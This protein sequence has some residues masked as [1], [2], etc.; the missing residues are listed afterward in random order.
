[1]RVFLS[2][3]GER[4]RAVAEALRD[5]LPNV[6]QA[7]EPWV[8]AS[9][10]E[11]GARWSADVARELEQTQVGVICLTS[12]NLNA[13][14]ILFETGALSKTLDNTF[15]CPYLLDITPTEVKAPLA[16]FQLTVAQKEDTRKLVHTINRAQRE[17]ALP[18]NRI[19][20][21]FDRFWP[22]LEAQLA[23]IP[24]AT[25][26]KAPPRPEREILEEILGIV[27]TLARDSKEDIFKQIIMLLPGT[28]EG[29]ETGEK[30]WIDMEKNIR[31]YLVNHSI[32]TKPF[33]KFQPRKTSAEKEDESNNKE[34]SGEE[35]K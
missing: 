31:N 14:W 16:Q 33:L 15:V 18:E 13:P 6:I 22:D 25:R 32:K 4:S 7:V 3:S 11:K 34:G 27:R 10:I 28:W 26:R 23:S 21:A 19:N 9:D 2:W 24:P 30:H 5:W 8:S 12:D 35:V 20:T 17:T 1:M 29:M